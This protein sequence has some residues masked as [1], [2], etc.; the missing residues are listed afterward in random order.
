MLGVTRLRPQHLQMFLDPALVAEEGFRFFVPADCVFV[1]VRARGLIIGEFHR[2]ATMSS[3]RSAGHGVKTRL[4]SSAPQ[5]ELAVMKKPKHWSQPTVR[6]HESREDRTRTWAGKTIDSKVRS[7]ARHA[8]ALERS[9][10]THRTYQAT[11]AKVEG[12]IQPRIEEDRRR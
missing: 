11:A 10:D 3:P 12:Q 2:N 9:A 1:R 8:A 7:E 6:V 5:T 4:S